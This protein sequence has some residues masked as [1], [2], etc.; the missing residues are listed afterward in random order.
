M[1][2]DEFKHLESRIGPGLPGE[3]PEQTLDRLRNQEAT[4][5]G[6]I[7][8]RQGKL[9]QIQVEI[10][11]FLKLHPRLEKEESLYQLMKIRNKNFYS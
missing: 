8:E 1:L 3:K 10:N 7:K 9:E 11:K 6:E 5:R 4:L 2:R